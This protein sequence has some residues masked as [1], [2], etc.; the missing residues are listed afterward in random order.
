DD[1][2]KEVILL[3]T[4]FEGKTKKR[5]EEDK[6]EAKTEGQK[7]QKSLL[8]PWMRGGNEELKRRFRESEKVKKGGGE[9]KEEESAELK[10]RFR[11]SERVKKKRG[12]D[13][14]GEESVELKETSE[15]ELERQIVSFDL[16][17]PPQHG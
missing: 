14:K 12:G 17:P 11:E 10:R 8:A 5:E 3:R 1:D 16:I 15:E 4:K 2:E 13:G 6:T 7:K 9:G